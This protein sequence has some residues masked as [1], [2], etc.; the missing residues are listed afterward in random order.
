MTNKWIFV[1]ID[2]STYIGNCYEIGSITFPNFQII[3]VVLLPDNNKLRI[4]IPSNN[5][6]T[7][8]P[9]GMMLDTN[10][11]FNFDQVQNKYIST[12]PGGKQLQLFPVNCY[13]KP[14]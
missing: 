7:I 5:P 3:Y 6:Y 14:I 11:I 4:T 10:Y 8:P 2:N 1:G 12:F 9:S 13:S